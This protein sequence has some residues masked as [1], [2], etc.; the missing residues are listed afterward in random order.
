MPAMIQK[1]LFYKSCS[2]GLRV[3]CHLVSNFYDSTV[4]K[5]TEDKSKKNG[6]ENEHLIS[7]DCSVGARNNPDKY[8]HHKWVDKIKAVENKNS[9]ENK[10]GGDDKLPHLQFSA[11]VVLYNTT[12]VS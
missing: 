4:Y 6:N 9:R 10:A 5:A 7:A 3:L 12:S 8:E 1:N 11:F 2:F